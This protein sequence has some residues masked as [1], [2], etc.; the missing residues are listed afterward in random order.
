MKATLLTPSANS[1]ITWMSSFVV[2]DVFFIFFYPPVF[3][4]SFFVIYFCTV[5]FRLPLPLID[6][7]FFCV[8]DFAK[9][10]MFVFIFLYVIFLTFQVSD[11]IFFLV[12]CIICFVRHRLVFSAIITFPFSQIC[13][14]LLLFLSA[15]FR[16]LCFYYCYLH[17]PILCSYTLYFPYT[18][19]S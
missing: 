6:L 5:I 14:P 9:L 18:L 3:L 10:V 1:F 7:Y 11:L 12:I 8:S 15:T 4:Q 16:L 13:L 17:F 19:F 2:Y